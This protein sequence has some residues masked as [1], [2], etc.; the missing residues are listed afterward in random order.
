MEVLIITGPPYSG[1]GTQCAILEG[2][3]GFSGHYYRC[4]AF[5]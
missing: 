1:K 2:H 5:V 3:L 4:A